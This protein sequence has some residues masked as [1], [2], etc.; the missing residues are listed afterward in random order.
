MKSIISLLLILSSA[1]AFGQN[2]AKASLIREVDNYV[3]T[4]NGAADKFLNNKL[5]TAER[6]KAIEPYDI[7]YYNQQIE[8]FRKIVLDEKEQPEIRAIALDKISQAV[9][10]DE[11]LVSL[12]FGWL[13]NPQ[14]PKVLR[15]EALQLIN[16]LSFSSMDVPDV[17]EKMLEDPEP[18]FR[19]FAFTKLIIHGDA[20]AQQK[21]IEGLENPDSALLPA[22]DAIGVLSMALKKEYY[23]TL[24]KVLQQTTDEAT[25]LEAIRSLGFYLEARGNLISISRN[26]NEKEE[27]REAALGAL[28]A[29]DREN[30]VN[31]VFPLLMDKNATLRLQIIGIQMAIDV[32]QLVSYRIKAKKADKFDLLIQKLSKDKSKPDLQQIAIKYI[33]YVRPK[34]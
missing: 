31:Y 24:Y 4:V 17:C 5:S 26:P 13:G 8:Q 21:L 15:E 33:Q 11:R 19:L 23:P 27:F 2:S 32:R 29:G 34:Y 10:D 3:K 30:I 1:I 20:R 28:Y 9:Q 6:I 18:E 14:A 22:P 7:I 12:A 25:K 16:D